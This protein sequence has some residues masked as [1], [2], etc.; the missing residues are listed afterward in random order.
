MESLGFTTER[1]HLNGVVG[2]ESE[3]ESLE[4][5]SGSNSP[6]VY[7]KILVNSDDCNSRMVLAELQAVI[8]LSIKYLVFS[9]FPQS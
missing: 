7:V 2:V 5:D 9:Q 8:S 4:P 1:T 6:P 3:D